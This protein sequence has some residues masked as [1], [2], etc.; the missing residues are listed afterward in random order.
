MSATKTI[1]CFGDSLTWGWVPVPG[2][3][4]TTRYPF[5][6]RWTGAMAERLGPGYHVVEEGLSGRTTDVDD[7]NDPRLRASAY[8][9]AILASHMPLDLVVL[10]LGTNDT[11]VFFRRSPFDIAYGMAKLVGQVAASAGG[12]GTCYP[13]PEVLVVAPP[14]LAPMQPAFFASQFDGAIE[15]TRALVPLYRDMA[16]CLGAGFLDAGA[17]IETDGCDG[18]HLTSESNRVFGR[19]I[20]DH[21]AAAL[22]APAPRNAFA[23]NGGLHDVHHPNAP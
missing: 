7:P 9:P 10:M 23:A 15:K 16:T 22:A 3:L 11:K 21:I 20:A 2:G 1:L 14:P 19:A 12:V 4:P 13:A 6:D 5:A 18:V 8:L 17:V